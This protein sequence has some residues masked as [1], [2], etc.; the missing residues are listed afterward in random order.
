MRLNMI[1]AKV[2]LR[3]S[4]FCQAIPYSHSKSYAF[5]CEVV[6]QGQMHYIIFDKPIYSTF[7]ILRFKC[8]PQSV[9]IPIFEVLGNQITDLNMIRMKILLYILNLIYERNVMI[10]LVSISKKIEYVL[11]K[12]EISD[13]QQIIKI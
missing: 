10:S 2:F 12:L 4:R 8:Q 3:S 13:F 5:R 6:F 11:G 1:L 7:S 9:N